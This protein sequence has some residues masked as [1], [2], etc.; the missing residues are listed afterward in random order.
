MNV[1]IRTLA[2]GT[3]LLAS[4]VAAEDRGGEV[5]GLL[6]TLKSEKAGERAGSARTLGEIGPAAKDAV[7]DLG[8]ALK[9]A[10]K[11][12]RRCAAQA[13]GDI[14][15]AAASAAGALAGAVKDADWQVRR[16][17]AYSL[18]RLGTRD[19]EAALKTAKDDSHEAVRK[20][21]KTSLDRIKK[22]P[23]PQKTK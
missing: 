5:P 11:E 22:L 23:K 14:G 2:L 19:V 4:A 21:A 20:A 3:M 8:A 12:V 9:D 13:L 10:D 17:A 6:V 15:P 18:G 7:G 1:S 16:A